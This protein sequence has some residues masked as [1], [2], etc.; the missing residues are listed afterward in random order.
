MTNIRQKLLFFFSRIA[1]TLMV[2]GYT[3]AILFIQLMDGYAGSV[4]YYNLG[5]NFMLVSVALGGFYII[6][7][8]RSYL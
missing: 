8:V 3:I 6:P 1:L 5:T 2:A 4:N 7:S